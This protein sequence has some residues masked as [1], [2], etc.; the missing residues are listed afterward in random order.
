MHSQSYDDDELATFTFVNG[1]TVE[2]ST[3]RQPSRE[4]AARSN[5]TPARWV[6]PGE[7]IT[8]QNV[9]INHGHFYF[10]GWLKTHS[11][12]EYGYLY[13]D[14]S[15]ASLVNDTF[16][17][18]PISRHYYDESLGYWPTFATLSPRCR[19]AYTRFICPSPTSHYIFLSPPPDN[20]NIILTEHKQS[21]RLLLYSMTTCN[22]FPVRH[23]WAEHNFRIGLLFNGELFFS[24][25]DVYFGEDAIST[26]RRLNHKKVG[27]VTDNFMA[28]SGKTRYLINEMPQASVSIFSAVTPDPSID[29]LQAGASQFKTFKPDVIIALGGGSSLDAAKGIKVT[30]EEYFPDHAIELIAIPTTSGSGSEVTSYAII[31]D[32]ENGRKYPLID[33]K[34]VPDCAILDPHLVLSVPRQVAVDTGMDVLTHAIEALVS[35]RANDF[36]DALAEKAIALVWH[37]LPIVFNDEKNLDARTH[38]HNASC[39]AG[40]AFNSAGLGLVH[41]MAHAIGGMLHIP[42]GKI[43][44]MLLPLIIEFNAE[45]SSYARE[46]YLKCATMMDIQAATPQQ[47]IR[48]LITHLQNMNRHF[49]IPAT[50]RALSVDITAFETLRQPLITAALA[51]GCIATNPCAPLSADIDR[52]LT[53]IAG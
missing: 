10:G 44:A 48:E 28:T 36:S 9:V 35:S 6:K 45:R 24:I 4:S 47:T 43:N 5:T 39:M 12:G 19:G 37:F 13:N 16:P 20:S 29:I 18:E 33:D 52:L 42:H 17:I 50:L 7:S 11:S 1:Q 8:I 25:P 51:D 22:L 14:G 31:S 34:L 53:R 46:R 40:M 49:G 3:S 41:G 30:L 15:D 26:L 23:R 27:I 2:Y 21:Q 32:P 38:M